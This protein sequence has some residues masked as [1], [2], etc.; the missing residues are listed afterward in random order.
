MF[1][2]FITVILCVVMLNS[3]VFAE[4][5][6]IYGKNYGEYA[7]EKLE[8]F[9]IVRKPFEKYDENSTITRRDMMKMIYI[10]VNANHLGGFGNRNPRQYFYHFDKNKNMLGYDGLEEAVENLNYLSANKEKYRWT[11]YE[12]DDVEFAS[13]DHFFATSLMA[14]GLLYGVEENGKFYAEFDREATY[15]EA[16]ISLC[17]MFNPARSVGLSCSYPSNYIAEYGHDYM[18]LAK[19]LGIIENDNSVAERM[20]IPLDNLDAPIKAYEFMNLLNNALYIPYD[21]RI[22]DWSGERAYEYRYFEAFTHVK[23]VET[24]D[25]YEAIL[26]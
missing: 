18:E 17:Y 8:Q 9:D 21:R 5:K 14:Y 16:I 10:V 13:E 6:R 4:E 20:D 25:D 12:F 11:Y 15:S 24:N 1:K 23:K 2:R 26:D 7:V 3:C 22:D 19:K